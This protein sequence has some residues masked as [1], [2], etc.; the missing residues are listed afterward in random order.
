MSDDT[1]A[2]S[3]VLAAIDARGIVTLTLNRADK[4][5]AYDAAM[6]ET[7]AQAFE[8]YGAAP[9]TRAIVLQGAGRHFCAGA[10]VRRGAEPP[11]GQRGISDICRLI[12]MTP[13]PTLAAVQGACIGGGLALAAC[14]D[15]VV[16]ADTAFFALPEVRL[17]FIPGPLGLLFGRKLGLRCYRRY[18]LTGQRFDAEEALRIG[19]AH[20]LC[21][22]PA[23]DAVLQ[24]QL[25]ESLLAAP[26]AARNAKRMGL[27]LAGETPPGLVSRLQA[28]FLGMQ[29]S[30]EAREGRAS[31]RDR[32]APAWYTT[33]GRK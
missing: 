14:C 33:E 16:A 2:D 23:L 20:R 15:I 10:D 28:E 1:T 6:Q 4:A 12:D 19:F 29:A 27:Q 18:A 9:R 8:R 22:A 21:E 32:R 25:D 30:A 5:N 13:C 7:L 26:V 31:F 11:P 17:G 3:S 24:Q